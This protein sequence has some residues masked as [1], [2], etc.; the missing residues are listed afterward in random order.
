MKNMAPNYL[1]RL[2]A[3]ENLVRPKNMQVGF[4]S[5]TALKEGDLIQDFCS[6][7]KWDFETLQDASFSNTGNPSFD[8]HILKVMEQAHSIF[9]T[10]DIGNIYNFL[11]EA[12]PQNARK[13]GT[14]PLTKKRRHEIH[15]HY[16]EQNRTLVARF[17]KPLTYEQTFG[18]NPVDKVKNVSGGMDVSLSK[19]IG[20][21]LVLQAQQ[22]R[23]NRELRNRIRK[24]E[25]KLGDVDTKRDTDV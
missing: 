6:R 9:G 25:E 24:L 20:Y 16:A 23:Q 1:Q 8:F 7:L 14:N 3:W 13:N 21:M 15:D 5:R 12:L 17:M 4:L 22:N 2:M 11:E 18:Q 10:Q 19:T